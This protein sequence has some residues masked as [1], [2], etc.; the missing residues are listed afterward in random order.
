MRGMQAAASLADDVGASFRRQRRRGR[1]NK[2]VE[3]APRQQRHHEI[4]FHY[5][6]F[7]EFPHVENLDDIGVNHG[8]EHATFAVEEVDEDSVT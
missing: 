4:R 8:R 2:I 5:T 3:R 7:F 1:V 6:V